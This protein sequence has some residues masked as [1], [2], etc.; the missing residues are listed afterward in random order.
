MSHR[1][2]ATEGGVRWKRPDVHVRR[3]LGVELRGRHRAG[4]SNEDIGLHPASRDRRDLEDALQSALTGRPDPL[5]IAV[6]A[7]F[8]LRMATQVALRTPL[9]DGTSVSGPAFL[10][11]PTRPGSCSM[12]VLVTARIL[13]RGQIAW[14]PIVTRFSS[15]HSGVALDHA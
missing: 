5:G 2:E 11:V 12:S 4:A 9:A 1:R 15:S 14:D 10:Y 6:R 3:H 7:M 8:D 13:F